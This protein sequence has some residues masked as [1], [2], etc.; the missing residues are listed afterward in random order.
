[1]NNIIFIAV[2][3]HHSIKKGTIIQFIVTVKLR[4]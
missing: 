4:I 3:I 2:T 1:L